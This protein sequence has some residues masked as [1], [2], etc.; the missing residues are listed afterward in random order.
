MR[1]GVRSKK[2]FSE[3]K[4]FFVSHDKSFILHESVIAKSGRLPASRETVPKFGG[5]IPLKST[6]G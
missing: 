1:L 4:L 3:V 2:S 5:T 6:P